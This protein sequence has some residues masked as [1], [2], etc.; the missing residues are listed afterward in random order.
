MK[1]LA[2]ISYTINYDDNY[3][4]NVKSLN[5]KIFDNNLI[6]RYIDKNIDEISVINTKDGYLLTHKISDGYYNESEIVLQRLIGLNILNT[7]TI[8]D[9]INF[10]TPIIYTKNSICNEIVK[11]EDEFTYIASDINH[12]LLQFS[13]SND[14]IVVFHPVSRSIYEYKKIIINNSSY[15]FPSIKNE[16]KHIIT[17][18]GTISEYYN[19]NCSKVKEY[20][21]ISNNG[22]INEVCMLNKS[23]LKSEANL[24]LY[25]LSNNY[26]KYTFNDSEINS[27]LESDDQIIDFLNIKDPIHN[28]A[29]DLKDID[30]II[31]PLFPEESMKGNKI[32]FGNL[33]VSDRNDEH[34]IMIDMLLYHP[35]D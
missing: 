11:G 34:I 17:D 12:K 19:D 27:I 7:A 30:V 29:L 10:A 28:Y 9:L 25:Y 8:G 5:I 23:I 1:N 15:I 4:Y 6:S 14:T 13:F 2:K 35:G 31:D 26:K 22:S 32:S 20:I 24:D 16:S 33:S 3:D 21:Y 18:K